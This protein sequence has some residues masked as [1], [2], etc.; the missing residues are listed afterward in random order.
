MSKP[1]RLPPDQWREIAGTA[2]NQLLTD[3]HAPDPLTRAK[4]VRQLCPCRSG[5]EL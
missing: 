5:P 3:L 2:L 4:A 1:K